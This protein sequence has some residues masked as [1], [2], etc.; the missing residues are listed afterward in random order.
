[1]KVPIGERRWGPRHH[2]IWHWTTEYAN[3]TMRS[4]HRR[5]T[6]RMASNK[7]QT[8]HNRRPQ[9]TAR[10]LADDDLWTLWSSQPGQ[11]TRKGLSNRW[12][13]SK[14]ELAFGCG[15]QHSPLVENNFFSNVPHLFWV[16]D[17]VDI[18]LTHLETGIKCCTVHAYLE[19]LFFGPPK[20][21][22]PHLA[23]GKKSFF[24]NLKC[25]DLANGKDWVC[26]I[27]WTYR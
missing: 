5:Q 17:F 2:H 11:T 15:F 16:C 8:A 3:R 26:K 22:C 6:S 10:A 4:T 13:W 25:Y 27:W 21:C 14:R 9:R 12:N 1:M 24:V 20:L 19:K 7:W 18:Y 23:Q